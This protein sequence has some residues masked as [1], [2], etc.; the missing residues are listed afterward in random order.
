MVKTGSITSCNV[1]NKRNFVVVTIKANNVGDTATQKLNSPSPPSCL[2]TL[3]P[4]HKPAPFGAKALCARGRL[5]DQWQ[6]A[7]LI[8]R[9]FCFQQKLRDFTSNDFSN[10]MNT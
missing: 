4:Q 6:V 3:Y 10:V 9:H 5:T 8:I 1:G 2:S 7:I